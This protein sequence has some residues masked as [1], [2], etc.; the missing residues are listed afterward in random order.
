MKT[1]TIRKK[2]SIRSLRKAAL[3]IS[4]MFLALI[5]ILMVVLMF[6]V[7]Q[8]RLGQSVP[9]AAGFQIYVVLGGSMSPVFE[10]GSIVL[11]Q[12]LEASSISQ[13]DIITY[14]D[15][16][17]GN[18]GIIVTHRVIEVLDTEPVSF[19]T[20]GDANDANDPIPVSAAN[21]LGRVAYSIPFLGSLLSFTRTKT[22]LM[23]MV[24][25]PAALIIFSEL[26]KLLKCSQ[27]LGK[28]K[29]KEVSG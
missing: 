6:F 19:V 17:D 28:T 11:V 25:V 12:P 29:K 26:R 22:G 5:M 27:D 2:D 21:L 9:S 3:V 18:I 15:P 10:A 13:G 24:I 8:S 14:R 4:R 1:V 23:V 20:R 7:L 16:G